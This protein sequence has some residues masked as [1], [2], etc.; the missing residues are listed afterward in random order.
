MGQVEVAFANA[1]EERAAR[2]AAMMPTLKA[3]RTNLAYQSAVGQFQFWLGDGSFD[4]NN[5]EK[6]LMERCAGDI[7]AGGKIFRAFSQRSKDIAVA[8]LRDSGLDVFPGKL[9]KFLWQQVRQRESATGGRPILRAQPIGAD[10][11]LSIADSI[12]AAAVSYGD[13]LAARNEAAVLLAF[14]ALMRPEE[15]FALADHEVSRAG[16]A[17]TLYF[18]QRKNHT[19]SSDYSVHLLPHSLPK[20][21]GM[22]SVFATLEC[23][24]D[25]W[26]YFRMDLPPG[27]YFCKLHGVNAGMRI[28]KVSTLADILR[29]HCGQKEGISGYSLRRGGVV[30]RQKAE[31]GTRDIMQVGGWSCP[32]AYAAYGYLN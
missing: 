26:D 21:D 27:A 2:H 23:A 13:A 29:K 9:T 28:T 12:R 16:G 22:D 15:V 11:V 20:P 3:R 17:L 5:A 31:Q 19:R 4:A 14:C 8:A 25:R 6:Y 32:K 24:L 18:P 10:D 7:F 30:A 1:E